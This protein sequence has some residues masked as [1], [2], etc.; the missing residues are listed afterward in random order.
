MA[1]NKP[2][3]KDGVKLSEYITTAHPRTYASGVPVFCAYDAIVPVN[4]LY[5][6][7]KNPNQHPPEQIK[8]LGAIIRATGWRGSIT[9]SNRSGLIVKGHGRLMAAELEDLTDVPVEYQ[10]Y[11][12]EAE[13]LADLTADN[14]IAELSTTDNQLLAAIFADIDT[15]EI[16]FMLSGYTEEEHEEIV[17]ALSDALSDQDNA[18]EAAGEAE[19][20]QPRQR[21]RAGDVWILGDYD[22]QVDNGLLDC[23]DPTPGTAKIIIANAPTGAADAVIDTI[24]EAIGTDGIR[25]VRRGRELALCEAWQPDEEGGGQE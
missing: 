21:V 15:G 22:E 18:E 10:D 5:P 4:E 7:P 16:P 12:S 8:A 1:K 13:E 9:V 17:A 11:A 3:P 25:C 14:R 6:N 19:E 2:K 24:V 20:Q 23:I